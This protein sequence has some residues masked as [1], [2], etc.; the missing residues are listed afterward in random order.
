[1]NEPLFNRVNI[2]EKNTQHARRAGRDIEA[3]CAEYERM[4]ADVGGIDCQVLQA[5]GS[6]GHIAS[7]EPG[8]SLA[9][10]THM[11]P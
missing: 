11:T 5:C 6:N 1:M 2:D 7:D 4:I 10:R 3:H 8:T 9:S